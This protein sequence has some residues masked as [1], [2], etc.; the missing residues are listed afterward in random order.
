MEVLPVLEAAQILLELEGLAFSFNAMG[1]GSDCEF[2]LCGDK[3]E[4][5]DCTV[6]ADC[7]GEEG[8]EV[9]GGAEICFDFANDPP[10]YPAFYLF[11]EENVEVCSGLV[12]VN[13]EDAPDTKYVCENSWAVHCFAIIFK[14]PMKWR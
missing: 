7:W 13:L 5:N 12:C 1:N 3:L 14:Q 9:L 6:K 2:V 11:L 8:D 4:I 10:V